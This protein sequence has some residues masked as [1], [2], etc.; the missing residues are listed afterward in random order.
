MEGAGIGLWV[1][2]H[3]V[4]ALGG[5]I[6]VKSEVGI[7]ST[8]TIT[9]PDIVMSEKIMNPYSKPKEEN[10]MQIMEVELSDLYST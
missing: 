1:V 4:E 9:F 6:S 5:E 10:F 7:G 8:F 2:K 3:F